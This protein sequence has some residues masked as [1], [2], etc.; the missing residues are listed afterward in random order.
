MH[1]GKHEHNRPFERKPRVTIMIRISTKSKIF[2][3]TLILTDSFVQIGSTKIPW[4]QIIHFDYKYGVRRIQ[5]QKGLEFLTYFIPKK[6]FYIYSEYIG[7]RGYLNGQ[8]YSFTHTSDEDKIG[9]SL[10]DRSDYKHI[11]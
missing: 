10:I 7:V 5:P 2:N 9:V 1:Q 11:K 6:E 3:Q 8:F 4:N